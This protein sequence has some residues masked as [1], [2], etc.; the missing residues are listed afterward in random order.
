MERGKE[1]GIAL[2]TSN[3]KILTPLGK[4]SGLKYFLGSNQNKISRKGHSNLIPPRL[5]PLFK[6]IP[7]RNKQN[8][9][10]FSSPHSICNPI[11]RGEMQDSKRYHMEYC[12]VHP[13]ETK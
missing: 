5:S 2:L 9:A 11:S 10:C 4:I 8:P 7:I 3:N 1:G 12:A 6:D 13:R